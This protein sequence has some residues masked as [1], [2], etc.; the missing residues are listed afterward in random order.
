[1][2]E[3]SPNEKVDVKTMYFPVDGEIPKEVLMKYAA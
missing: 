2:V 3:T 1:M